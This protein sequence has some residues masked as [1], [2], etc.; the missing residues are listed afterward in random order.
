MHLLALAS[1]SHLPFKICFC[2]SCIAWIVT[3]A[4]NNTPFLISGCKLVS[5]GVQVI[6][7]WPCIY[8]LTAWC[9]FSWAIV[10]FLLLCVLHVEQCC[11][12]K[13]EVIGCRRKVR[14]EL[15]VVHEYQ[16]SSNMCPTELLKALC[17]HP[18]GIALRSPL[19]GRLALTLLFHY[20]PPPPPCGVAG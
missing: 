19:L 16:P 1:S 14:S 4:S 11:G 5:T 17:L 13:R 6:L 3:I 12:A 8:T 18:I 15:P 10:C 7:P 20:V 9:V 2:V